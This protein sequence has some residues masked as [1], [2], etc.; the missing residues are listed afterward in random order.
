MV[1]L[2]GVGKWVDRLKDRWIEGYLEGK[3]NLSQFQYRHSC[4]SKRVTM[5]PQSLDNSLLSPTSSFSPSVT[6]SPRR[7]ASIA[8][9]N[10]LLP[11]EVTHSEPQN[12]RAGANFRRFCPNPYGSSEVSYV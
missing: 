10:A 4:D 2:E 12:Q 5:N 3:V 7:D 6:D 1:G 9:L 11:S 8:M